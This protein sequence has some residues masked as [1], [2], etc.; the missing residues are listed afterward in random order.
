MILKDNVYRQE[1][2]ADEMVLGGN[3]KMM[4]DN[5]V[6]KGVHDDE[7]DGGGD[8]DLSE[9]EK[10]KLAEEKIAAEEKARKEKAAGE[11]GSEE[12]EEEDEL[13]EED[14]VKL[15][16]IQAKEEDQLTDEEKEFLEKHAPTPTLIDSIKDD[17]EDLVGEPIEG[18]FENNNEGAKNLVSI[19]ATKIATNLVKEHF[20]K[21]PEFAKVYNHII[22][23]G[24]SL[25]TLLKKEVKPDFLSIE[26]K[27]I[28]DTNNEEENNKIIENQKKVI[29][30]Y[31]EKKGNSPDDIKII[32]E[33][34]ETNNKLFDKAKEAKQALVTDY[35]A[36]VK[37]ALEQEEQEKIAAAEKVKEQW[38]TVNKIISTNTFDRGLKIPVTDIKAFKEALFNR[39]V[40]GISLMDQKRAKLSLADR[41]LLDYFIW[42]D[43]KVKGLDSKKSNTSLDFSKAVEKNKKRKSADIISDG[44]KDKEFNIKNVDFGKLMK[45]ANS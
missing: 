33:A 8:D 32:L 27:D 26:L 16:E 45:S 42:K 36:S 28:S 31:L 30:N 6:M 24:R 29:S 20:T 14:Q 11:D 39:D 2:G 41:V 5:V 4:L 7:E 19:A 18:E 43:F 23:E 34:H 25:D 10:L 15:K 40:R 44:N 37:I 9:E 13:S 38:D 1:Q 21:N 17:F 22:T 12:E 35:E 3:L